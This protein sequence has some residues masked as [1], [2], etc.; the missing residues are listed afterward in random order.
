MIS[1]MS[2][3]TRSFLSPHLQDRGFLPVV[4][5]SPA[6]AARIQAEKVKLEPG[7]ALC[8]PLI[9]G[10]LQYT[11]LGTCT[12]VSGERILGFG[13]QML[14]RGS[15]ELPMA[16]GMVHTVIP[17]LYRSHK[18]GAA[19]KTVGTLW[20]DE[21]SGIFGTCGKA[22]AMIGLHDSVRRE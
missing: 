15:I 18:I 9:S 17:S 13:H 7:S 1:S 19:I 10:D 2:D 11:A 5:G 6:P 8:I 20:G 4:S 3:R 12:E 22:P 21:N 16:T 14:G